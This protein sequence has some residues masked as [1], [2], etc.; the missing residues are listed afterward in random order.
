LKQNKEAAMKL[1]TK[2]QNVT[3]YCDFC[4]KSGREVAMID[5]KHAFICDECVDVARSLLLRP[6]LRAVK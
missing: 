2:K 6:R 5:G 3:C 1:L 4:G